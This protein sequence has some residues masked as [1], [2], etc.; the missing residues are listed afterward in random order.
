MSSHLQYKENIIGKHNYKSY[1]NIV[2][3]RLLE[4]V[5]D[6]EQGCNDCMGKIRNCLKISGIF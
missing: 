2:K 5:V 3:Q 1:Q 6:S 4:A